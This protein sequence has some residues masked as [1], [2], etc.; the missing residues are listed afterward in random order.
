MNIEEE[1]KH[2]PEPEK[3]R[4]EKGDKIGGRHGYGGIGKEYP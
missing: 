2:S 1:K 4:E 3:K